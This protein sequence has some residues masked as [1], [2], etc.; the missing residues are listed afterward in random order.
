[1]AFSATRALRRLRQAA[2]WRFA[3]QRGEVTGDAC[4]GCLEHDDQFEQGSGDHFDVVEVIAQVRVAR[5]PGE[6]R[7]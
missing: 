1:M 3:E 4:G 5:H 7:E 6:R 2:L